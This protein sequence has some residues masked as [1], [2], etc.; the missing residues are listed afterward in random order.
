MDGGGGGV[1][2]AVG[3][4]ASD[5]NEHA[6]EGEDAGSVCVS[7]WDSPIWSRRGLEIDEKKKMMM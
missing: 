3:P 2:F 4:E 5:F 7:D 1:F 6:E